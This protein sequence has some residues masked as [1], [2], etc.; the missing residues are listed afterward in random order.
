[1]AAGSP[2]GWGPI[3][4]SSILT[5]TRRNAPAACSY[6]PG[7]SHVLEGDHV[8]PIVANPAVRRVRSG[9]VALGRTRSPPR[10]RSGSSRVSGSS[11]QRSSA[12]LPSRE[13]SDRAAGHWLRR[14]ARGR[15]EARNGRDRRDGHLRTGDDACTD[16]RP[17]GPEALAELAK[18]SSGS[19]CPRCAR[20]SPAAS[21]TITRS[22]WGGCSPTSRSSKPT[23][24]PSLSGSSRRSAP[25]S[26]R[27]SCWTRS[28]ALTAAPPR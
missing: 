4:S 28:R 20:R 18:G 27:W 5:A 21:R 9:A 8:I 26:W 7:S 13:Q 24:R 3:R 1:M 16:R 17:G 22:C 12:F 15:R 14:L 19:S 10:R 2:A 23:S 25:S 11:P 6:R